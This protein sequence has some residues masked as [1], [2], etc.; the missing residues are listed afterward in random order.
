MFP[1]YTFPW[2]TD[3]AWS[4]AQLPPGSP[5]SP[6]GPLSPRGPAG[7]RGPRGPGGPRG[8]REDDAVQL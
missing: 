7:P 5:F 2:A 8:P 6:L 4:K 3:F 1:G